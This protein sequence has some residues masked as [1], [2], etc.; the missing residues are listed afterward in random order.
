MAIITNIVK[1]PTNGTLPIVEKAGDDKILEGIKLNKLGTP[2]GSMDGKT[3]GQE[4]QRSGI[5]QAAVQ[6][7]ALLTFCTN[8]EEWYAAVER[9]ADK[10]LAWVKK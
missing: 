3:P 8:E 6:A 5:I 2:Y 10:M 7:S 4:I 1:S 9:T